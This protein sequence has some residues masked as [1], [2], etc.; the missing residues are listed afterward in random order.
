MS[1][2]ALSPDRMS[3]AER[4][5]EIGE[6]LAAGLIRLRARQREAEA[7]RSGES[8]LDFPADQSVHG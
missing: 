7:R 8:S 6:I 4:L 2:N 5:T 3:A 1:S